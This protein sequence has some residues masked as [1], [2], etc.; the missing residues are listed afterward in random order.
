MNWKDDFPKENRYYETDNG[1]LYNGDAIEIMKRLPSHSIDTVITDVPYGTINFK[2]DCKLPTTIMW[3]ELKRIRKENTAILLFGSEPFITKLCAT[4]IDEF[5]Y[6]LVWVKSEITNFFNANYHPMRS[7]EIISV[8]Y[9]KTTKYNPQGLR[10]TTKPRNRKKADH[11]HSASK[12][13]YVQQ[14]TNYPKDVIYFKNHRKKS[15]HPTQKPL[16]LM[17]Y[18][19]KTYSDE[20]DIVLDFTCGS[21]STLIASKQVNRRWIGIEISP[22]YCEISKNRLMNTKRINEIKLKNFIGDE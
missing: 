21:G 13:K 11:W 18:L 10:V 3:Q 14:F 8:F 19:I 2:W 20:N 16:N 7:H 12:M 22:E 1:I 17:R 9:D 6:N 5:R 15:L 4:N